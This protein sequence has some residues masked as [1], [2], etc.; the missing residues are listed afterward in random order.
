MSRKSQRAAVPSWIALSSDPLHSGMGRSACTQAGAIGIG[1]AV[2]L[3]LGSGVAD[4]SG[5][6]L[7]S[8]VADGCGVGLGSGVADG[9]GVG[10]GG[11][12]GD[13]VGPSVGVPGAARTRPGPASPTPLTRPDAAAT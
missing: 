7:G 9:C 10:G 4:G 12:A 1:A 8:G 5:V 6:G 2:G 13:D 3:G 11:G